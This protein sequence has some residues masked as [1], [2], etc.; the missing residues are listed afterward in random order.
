MDGK[1]YDVIYEDASF[2]YPPSV[3]MSPYD[4]DVW[5]SATMDEIALNPK[6]KDV[7][8]DKVIYWKLQNSHC[9]TIYRDRQWFAE[10]L[11]KL[12]QVW[13]YVEFFRL[14][15]RQLELWDKYIKST[16]IDAL[17]ASSPHS[18]KI[19]FLANQ[20]LDVAIKLCETNIPSAEYE[21]YMTE[22]TEE[23]NHPKPKQKTKDPE[24]ASLISTCQFDD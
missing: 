7:V 19:D 11:P 2:I 15:P 3:E 22:L 12:K 18:S 9:V 8:F 6:Y 4:C 13:E 16:H 20:I 1:Y 14:N 5:V 10:N 23:I 17:K 24:M 21:K